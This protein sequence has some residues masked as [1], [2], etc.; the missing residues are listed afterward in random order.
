M[1]NLPEVIYL[2]KCL[3]VV[4]KPPGLLSIPDGHD[5]EKPYLKQ[6]LEPEFGKLWIVHRLDKDTSGVIILP[7][8]EITHAH[9]N[10]Q[11]SDRTVHKEYHSIV[12]GLP[13]WETVSVN[14]PLRANVGR[15]KRTIVDPIGGKNAITNFRVLER[16]EKHAVVEA[17]PKTGRTHQIRTH[18]YSIGHPVLADHIYGEDSETTIISRLALH[19]SSIKIIHPEL[20]R[21]CVFKAP[22]FED[23]TQAVE[24][25]RKR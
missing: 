4:N 16:F 10:N 18:L 1:Q 5:P 3:V 2:D 20:Q 21:T 14:S 17:F 19:A 7:R 25:L 12:K 22:F 6:V 13:T 15:R 24:L 8:D 9:L 11:F 23:F